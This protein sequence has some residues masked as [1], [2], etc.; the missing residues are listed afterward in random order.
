M[1]IEQYVKQGEKYSFSDKD[2]RDMTNNMYDIY[3][4]ENLSKYNNINDILGENKGAVILF[5]NTQN[6]GHWVSIWL[7][8]NILHF[9]D[10]YGLAPDEELKYAE[11]NLRMH[12][13]NKVPHLSHLIQNS[14]YKL[15]Y[16]KYK[17][18]KSL[19]DTSTCGR[20][21]TYRL[22]HR[23][24]SCSEFSALFK[25]NKYYDPDFWITIIT[26]HWGGFNSK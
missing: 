6:S 12:N 25:N 17:L 5:Q 15:M 21:I 2:I 7:E 22:L 9:F 13:N 24:L 16:N 20:W 14:G 4:Y 10:S 8:N 26:A 3:T 11:Y 18:Q 19:K 23:N 1:S